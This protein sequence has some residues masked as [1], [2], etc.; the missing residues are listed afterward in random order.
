MAETNAELRLGTRGSQLALWQ[1][2]AVAARLRE[3]SGRP[4][5]IVVIPIHNAGPVDAVLTWSGGAA[6]LDLTLFQTGISKPIVRSASAGRGPEEVQ[7]TLTT[8]AT[9]E[10]RITY[11]GGSGR[12]AYTLRV[13]HLN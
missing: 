2:H 9:Y 4:C 13:V 1:A 12:T 8:G 7:A 5:R 6:D 10:F 11:A 3:A